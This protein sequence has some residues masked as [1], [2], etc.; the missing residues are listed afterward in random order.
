LAKKLLKVSA[1]EA[2]ESL[3]KLLLENNCRVV[4]ETF[5][6]NIAVIHGSLWG[7]SSITAQ[8]RIC[9]KITQEPSETSIHSE[10]GLTSAYLKLALVGSVFSAILMVLCLWIAADLTSVSAGFWGFLIGRGVSYGVVNSDLSSLFVD[11]CFI[12][13]IFLMGSLAVEGAILVRVHKGVGVFSDQI[14]LRL[15]SDLNSAL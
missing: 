9:Y 4:D 7:A 2:F 12:L 15:Y 3:K 5:P 1:E 10:S 11:V 8:K 14:L 13:A 6:N